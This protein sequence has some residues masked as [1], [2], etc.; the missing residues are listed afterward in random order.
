VVAGLAAPYALLAGAGISLVA[1]GMMYDK[2]R[3]D[4]LRESPYSYLLAMK[5]DLA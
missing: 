3:R 4:S 1:A 5:N 2:E